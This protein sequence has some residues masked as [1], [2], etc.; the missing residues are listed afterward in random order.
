MTPPVFVVDTNVIVS[1]LISSDS[2]APP[3][4]ILEAMLGGGLLYLMSSDLLTE[5]ASVLRRPRLV[6]L[7]GRSEAEI[8]QLLAELTANAVWC[9]A[10][11]GD[12]APDAG[13]NHL[14]A[15]LSSWAGSHLIT[16]DR[17]LV[18]NASAGRLVLT[19]RDFVSLHTSQ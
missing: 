15:L 6:R 13:D 8:D 12:V 2:K 17:L 7:H 5:Y 16:G 10:A 3:A 19:P 4:Q 11:V 1:A 14:W 18:E 9:E